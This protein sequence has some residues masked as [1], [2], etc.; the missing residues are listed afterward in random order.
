LNNR[1]ERLRRRRRGLS[2]ITQLKSEV[3]YTIRSRSKNKID[4][5]TLRRAER[6]GRKLITRD[7]SLLIFKRL[8]LMS[9]RISALK[10]NIYMNY[11][12]RPF[13]SDYITRLA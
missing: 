7:K 3:K 6:S 11:R 8:R 4:L 12:R 9:S 5:T 10:I 2:K 1:K 13:H